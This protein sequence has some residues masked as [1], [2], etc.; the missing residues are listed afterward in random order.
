M[1]ENPKKQTRIAKEL[2]LNTQGFSGCHCLG[3]SRGAGLTKR[4]PMMQGRA[5][6]IPHC[7]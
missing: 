3:A 6:V 2:D 4:A 5:S 1:G 7:L